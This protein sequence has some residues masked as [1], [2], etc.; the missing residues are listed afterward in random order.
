MTVIFDCPTY[1]ALLT[2]ASFYI[3]RTKGIPTVSFNAGISKVHPKDKFVKKLGIVEAVK[4]Q[5]FEEFKVKY[6]ESTDRETLIVL[7]RDG[8]PDLKLNAEYA[9]KKVKILR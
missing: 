4:K 9:T 6:V 8:F 2:I 1:E 5:K 3:A 7:S